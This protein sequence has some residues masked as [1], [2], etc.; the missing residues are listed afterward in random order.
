MKSDANMAT[1]IFQ[2]IEADSLKLSFITT[3]GTS[4]VMAR[5]SAGF[6]KILV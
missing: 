2:V 1:V 4:T 5:C 3:M 6:Y